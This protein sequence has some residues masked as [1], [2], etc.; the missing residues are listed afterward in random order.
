[1][2]VENVFRP[3]QNARDLSRG[4]WRAV[5]ALALVA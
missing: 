3:D 2:N 4:R 1:M 5:A